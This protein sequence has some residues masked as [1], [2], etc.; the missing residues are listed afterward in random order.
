MDSSNVVDFVAGDVSLR[1][2]CRRWWPPVYGFVQ[3]GG[4]CGRQ[5]EVVVSAMWSR[6]WLAV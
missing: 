2:I 5:S 6:W 3:C 1:A 4:D